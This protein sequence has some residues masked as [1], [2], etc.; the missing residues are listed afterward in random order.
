[1]TAYDRRCLTV[2]ALGLILVVAALAATIPNPQPRTVRLNHV[3][4]PRTAPG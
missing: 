4:A 2:A 3:D 1:M